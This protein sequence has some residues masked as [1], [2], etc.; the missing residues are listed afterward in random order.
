LCDASGA[1]A[2]TSED[3]LLGGAIVL[4]QPRRGFRVAID[5]VL[6]AAAVPARPGERVFEPG[7]GCGAAALCLAHRTGC[8]VLGIEPQSDLVALAAEN[9]Q[10]N[11]L[12]ARVSVLRGALA[13]PLPAAADAVFDHAMANPPYQPA[14]W[15]TRPPD[16][17]RAAAH[18]EG[19][20][21][22]NDWIAAML[23]RLKPKGTLT[24]VHR[25]DRL[26]AILAA[27]E[28]RA[29]GVVVFP[30]WPRAGTPARRIIVRARKSARTPLVL[31]AGLAL[32]APGGR[33][34]AEADAVLRG[35]ALDF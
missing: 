26:D 15:G 30:L 19:G 2:E 21:A 22:L 10:A 24:L 25:A 14:G 8:S 33:Y 35:A 29:G 28:G 3:A 18:V 34:T 13:A 16:G 7:A 23:A 17:A 1:P 32:H 27:L 5:T 6:L 31:A 11:G 9:A 12:A 20:A 4:R